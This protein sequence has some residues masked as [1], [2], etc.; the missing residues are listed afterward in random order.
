MCL[1]ADVAVPQSQASFEMLL[2]SAQQ[3]QARGDFSTA[4]E[5]YRQAV[6]IHPEIAELKAN[7]GL[8]Y[9]QTGK[10]DE[11]VEAFRQAIRLKPQLFAPNLFLGRE[12]VK[13]KHFSVAIP[14]L[15]RAAFSKPSDINARVSLAEAYTGMGKT[16]LAIAS[17]SHAEQINPRDPDI[18]YHL[19]V[20]Y[21]DQ[22]EA[23]AR[24][25]LSR[26]K[27]SPYFPALVADN[28]S[29]QHEF[30]QAIDAYRKALAFPQVPP[31]I[32]ASFA[33]ALLNRQDISGAERELKSELQSNP[34][35]LMA[36]LGFARLYVDQDQDEE[37]TNELE[38][39]W[40]SDVGFL[41]ANAALFLAG[42][43]DPKR[44]EFLHTLEQRQE[45][46]GLSPELTQIF[47]NGLDGESPDS[48]PRGFTIEKLSTPTQGRIEAKKL[49]AQG[50]YQQCTGRLSK[51][52]EALPV[53]ELRMLAFCAYSTGDYQH[54]FD[55]GAKMAL[56]NGTEA[57]GLY[58]ET[59]SAQKLA[60][61]AMDRASAMDSGSPKLHV[62]LGDIYRERKFFSDAEREYRK[63]LA[64]RPDDTGALFGLCLTLLGDNQ[65]EEALRVAQSVLKN[66]SDDPELNAV[67]GEI[68]CARHEFA[69]AEPY[70]KKSLTTKPEYVPHVHAL[71]GKVYAQTGRT[72]QAIAELKL[73]LPDDKDGA[74]HYQIGRLYLKI[75]DRDSA[76]QALKISERLHNEGLNKAMVAMQEGEENSEPQ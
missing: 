45:N 23:D 6:A 73:A 71:L 19:G 29:E 8:M 4:A 14:Y 7:L 42:L 44:A 33:F 72:E 5:F 36:K 24:V 10:D 49:Y 74:V 53:T 27:D 68:L 55:A 30:I 1:L 65:I 54:A 48:T 22:V 9:Y 40:T 31:G 61:K 64:L 62:L 25:L 16:R 34:G 13:Q 18:W 11:A 51:R 3:A 66:N 21:L 63:A 47:R 75:G 76:K 60:A 52:L 41:Q 38:G 39:I 69:G 2:A 26:H 43:V 12:Y 28:F 59:K 17:Y 50:K 67:M 57:E 32:H 37:A 58:W 15:K 70:L 46:R 35:S 20:G 56:S